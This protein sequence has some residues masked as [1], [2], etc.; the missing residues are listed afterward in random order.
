MMSGRVN[1]AIGKVVPMVLRAGS[2]WPQR[3]GGGTTITGSL[4]RRSARHDRRSIGCRC[5][6]GLQNV[7]A[8]DGFELP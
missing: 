4:H 3:G 7:R 2:V 5:R 8:N 1:R 6:P